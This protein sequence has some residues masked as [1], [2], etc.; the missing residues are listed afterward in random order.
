M[1]PG[2]FDSPAGIRNIRLS[3][4]LPSEQEMTPESVWLRGHF[5]L[6]FGLFQP[7]DLYS[8][9]AGVR[10]GQA[11]AVVSLVREDAVGE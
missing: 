6:C 4:H 9:D 8:A 10:G 1:L 11:E 7:V 2:S 5:L 3:G